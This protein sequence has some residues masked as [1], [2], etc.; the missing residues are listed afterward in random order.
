MFRAVAM[1]LALAMLPACGADAERPSAPAIEP[2]VTPAPGGV[3]AVGR[4]QDL[5]EPDG[6]PLAAIAYYPAAGVQGSISWAAAMPRDHADSLILRFGATA[7]TALA[8]GRGH[9][10]ADAPI[11]PGPWPVLV[12]APGWRLTAYDYRALLEDLASRGFV[13]LAIERSPDQARPPFDETAAQIEAVVATVRALAADSRSDFARALDARHIGVLGHSVG[14][15]AA[16]LAAVADSGIGA[17]ANLDGDFG[18]ASEMARPGQ[19]MFYLTSVD[20]REP[21]RTRER[22]QRIWARVSADSDAAEAVQMRVLRHFNFLDAALVQDAIPADL[23]AGRFGEIDPTRGLAMSGAL[24]A[25]FFDEHLRARP[26]A[27]AATLEATPEA[28]LAE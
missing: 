6:A 10:L 3:H 22:R 20:P 5:T 28:A 9:A 25:A 7:A 16:A 15:A 26:G 18:G 4:R 13:V 12:F 24:T 14:G 21:V 27:L 2:V 23:R 11:A 1:V 8:Q 19:P 17:V